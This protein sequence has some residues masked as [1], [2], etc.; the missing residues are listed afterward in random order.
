MLEEGGRL[1]ITRNGMAR[2]G[3]GE[4]ER[5]RERGVYWTSARSAGDA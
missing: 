1:R 5:E 2:V 4:R 3:E